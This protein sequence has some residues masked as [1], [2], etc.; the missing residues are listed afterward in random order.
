[1]PRV[2]AA[3]GKIKVTSGTREFDAPLDHQS[4]FTKELGLVRK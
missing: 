4:R 1:L 2:K 3:T